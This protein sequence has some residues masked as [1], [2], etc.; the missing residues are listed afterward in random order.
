VPLELFVVVGTFIEELF[1]PIPSFIVLVPAGAVAD[2]RGAGAWYLLVLMV[3]SAVGRIGAA[4]ILYWLADK[5]E[6][7]LLNDGRRFF[8]IS[9]KEVERFGQRLG[10]AGRR[11]WAVLLL[12]NALPFFPAGAL[13]LGCGFVKVRYRMFLAC[14]F[15]GTMFNALFYLSI[16][17]LGFKTAEALRTVEVATQVTIGLLI[18][19]LVV[20]IIR[21]R[22][23]AKR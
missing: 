4:A 13:S 12:M 18:V 14:T 1:S 6:D 2:A 8:G 7:R 3:F 16:G 17:Y 20:W 22:R 11:D 10:R 21:K 5:F 19:G 9:H 23:A 15:F